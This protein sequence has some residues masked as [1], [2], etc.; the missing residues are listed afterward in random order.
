MN[1]EKDPLETTTEDIRALVAEQLGMSLTEVGAGQTLAE[2][3]ADDLDIVEIAIQVS[4]K[5][6]IPISETEEAAHFRPDITV[7]RLA[8]VVH[9]L[10][11]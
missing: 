10:W 3:G 5:F 8:E 1:N 7:G 4:E 9:K 6:D 2:L 11:N